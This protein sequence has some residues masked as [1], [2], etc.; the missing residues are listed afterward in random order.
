MLRMIIA[1]ISLPAERR[2]V[3]YI[4]LAGSTL[5]AA[6]AFSSEV[7]IKAAQAQQASVV[8]SAAEHHRGAGQA[9]GGTVLA[10][11]KDYP[12]SQMAGSFNLSKVE[13]KS[14]RPPARADRF[15]ASSGRDGRLGVLRRP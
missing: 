9:I 2:N 12:P 4:L 10:T 11:M 6:S 5:A 14:E 1:A 15:R 13:D 3:S 7:A 8:R